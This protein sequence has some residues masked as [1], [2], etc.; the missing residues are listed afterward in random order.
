MGKS[1]KK[2]NYQKDAGRTRKKFYRKLSASRLRL[3]TKRRI[4]REE[5][6]TMPLSN[7]LTNQWEV[8]DWI[9]FY[10]NYKLKMLYREMTLDRQYIV[11]VGED[12]WYH[13][14]NWRWYPRVKW[15]R[16]RY[17]FIK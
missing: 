7:E 17:R 15:F 10:S 14:Y 16:G 5:Y 1:F 3:E 6:D 2:N 4:K 13:Y 12:W 9:S 11:M 8:C